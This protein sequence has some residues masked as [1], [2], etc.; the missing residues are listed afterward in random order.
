MTPVHASVRANFFSL[1]A[2]IEAALPA[3]CRGLSRKMRRFR[4]GKTVEMR[5]WNVA[6]WNFRSLAL[7]A[8]VG[9]SYRSRFGRL[10]TLVQ[11]HLWQL[12]TVRWVLRRGDSIS[13]R[14]SPHYLHQAKCFQVRIIPSGRLPPRLYDSF[15]VDNFYQGVCIILPIVNW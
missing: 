13:E 6:R 3:R 15:A 1:T 10:L 11:Q 7:G 2:E 9:E 8:E 14:Y 5:R 4:T 12:I